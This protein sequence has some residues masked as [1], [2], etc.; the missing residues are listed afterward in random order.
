MKLSKRNILPKPAVISIIKDID[1]DS[2]TSSK[3]TDLSSDIDVFNGRNMC[4]QPTRSTD[5]VHDHT[6][7]YKVMKPSRR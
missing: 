4:N 2:N 5:S 6:I 7:D 1:Q 3:H